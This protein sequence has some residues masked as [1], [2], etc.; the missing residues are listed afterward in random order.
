MEKIFPVG[1]TN[2]NVMKYI[3]MS[4]DRVGT[5]SVR[6]YYKKIA[7]KKQFVVKINRTKDS[8]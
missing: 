7:G 1:T 6:V 4:L 3:V 5:N 8:S 2:Q